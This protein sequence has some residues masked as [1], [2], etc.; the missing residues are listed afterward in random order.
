L[1]RLNSGQSGIWEYKEDE[2]VKPMAVTHS[3]FA[4]LVVK[5]HVGRVIMAGSKYIFPL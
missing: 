3:R 4:N 2:K 5:M 1:G